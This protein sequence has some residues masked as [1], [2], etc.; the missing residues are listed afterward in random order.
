MSSRAA[1]CLS[2]AVALLLTETSVAAEPSQVVSFRK[3]LWPGLPSENSKPQEVHFYVTKKTALTDSCLGAHQ[4]EVSGFFDDVRERLQLGEMCGELIVLTHPAN[5]ATFSQLA[6][7]FVGIHETFHLVAQIFSGRS[8]SALVFDVRP[9]LTAGS[10][11]FFNDLVHSLDNRKKV[12]ARAAFAHIAQAYETLPAEDKAVVDFYSTVEWPSEYYAY[13]VL[14][15]DDKTWSRESY[16]TVRREIGFEPAYLA[17]I[18]TGLALDSVLGPGKWEDR[19]IKG[20]TMLH[21]LSGLP[22]TAPTRA[23]WQVNI[24]N[25]PLTL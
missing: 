22:A 11:Q 24:T 23:I 2:F 1:C 3:D 7:S 17:A 21:M 9:K 10:E 14:A 19:V 15:D 4:A 25:W 18:P 5:H 20:E 12:D 13:K 8:P 6:N 16:M